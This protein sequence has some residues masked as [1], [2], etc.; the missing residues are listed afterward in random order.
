MSSIRPVIRAASWPGETDAVAALFEEYAASLDV[1]LAY[2]DFAAELA[3][4]PGKYAAPSGA[5]IVADHPEHGLVGCV[6]LRPLPIAGCCEMKRLYVQSQG[7]GLGLGRMLISAIIR[8][9]GRLGYREM[10]L[11]TLP[12]MGKAMELYAA[13]GFERIEPYYQSPVAGTVFLRRSLGR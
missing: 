1:D 12:T 4:L 3:A 7:R 6:A 8:E 9:G 11:D 13:L 5:L 2:Q 10:R